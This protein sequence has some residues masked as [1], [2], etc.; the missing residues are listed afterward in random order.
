MLVTEVHEAVVC[1]RVVQYDYPEGALALF[2]FLLTPEGHEVLDPFTPASEHDFAKK[3]PVER[4]ALRRAL[5][6]VRLVLLP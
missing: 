1:R 2:K 3:T 4:C 5:D 6:A